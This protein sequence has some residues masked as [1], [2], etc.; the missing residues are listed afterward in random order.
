PQGMPQAVPAN[1]AQS[2]SSAQGPND[3]NGPKTNTEM[4]L[5]QP[6]QLQKIDGSAIIARRF[7]DTTQ[8]WCGPKLLKDLGKSGAEADEIVKAMRELRPTEWGGIGSG[9]R[10]VVEYGLT[11]GEP[12]SPTY[13]PKQSLN[14]DMKSVR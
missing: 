10:F 12:F 11:K 3:W 8:I 14:I 2:P 5:P 4:K 6:E 9:G 13:A 7:G 1:P